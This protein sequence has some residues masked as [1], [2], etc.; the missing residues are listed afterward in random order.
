M[1]GKGA[2][3]ESKEG[4]KSTWAELSFLIFQF[5]NPPHRK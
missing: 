3:K 5:L 1:L 2:G 4:W